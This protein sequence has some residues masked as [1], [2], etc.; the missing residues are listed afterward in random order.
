MYLLKNKLDE[1]NPA[2]ILAL[3]EEKVN[4]YKKLLF[5]LSP[6]NILERGYSIVKKDKRII[7]ATW[8]VR[9]GD[10]VEIIL[11]KGKILAKVIEKEE[12]F[13]YEKLSGKGDGN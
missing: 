13:S 8:E 2:H 9:E 10:L 11:S 7:K 3:K 12:G 5:S 1:K 4:G 6:Y